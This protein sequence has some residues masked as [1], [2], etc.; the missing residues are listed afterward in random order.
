MFSNRMNRVSL[1][2]PEYMEDLLAVVS[3]KE[4]IPKANFIRLAILKELE[5]YAE[6]V[7]QKGN[8]TNHGPVLD[9]FDTEADNAKAEGIYAY[10]VRLLPKL[11]RASRLSG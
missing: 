10:F 5:A 4:G 1:F 6:K 9:E 8:A 2:L 3:E 7:D 11:Q